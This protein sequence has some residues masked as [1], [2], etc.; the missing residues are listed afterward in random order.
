MF[1]RWSTSDWSGTMRDKPTRPRHPR[2]W[3]SH[4]E[5]NQNSGNFTRGSQ[6]IGHQFS[7]WWRG[8]RVPLLVWIGLLLGFAWLKLTLILDDY[9]FQMLGTKALAA[10]WNFVGFDEKIGRASCRERV[11]QY[12]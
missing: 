6:L 11:C 5:A 8:A 10:F 12:V 2:A 3:S 9:E 7:M 1:F 4:G